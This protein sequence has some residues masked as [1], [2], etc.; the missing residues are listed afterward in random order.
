MRGMMFDSRNVEVDPSSGIKTS[1]SVAI[2]NVVARRQNNVADIDRQYAPF[3]TTISME[4][5]LNTI[6]FA[7][8]QIC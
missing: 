3:C 8:R 4:L 1:F 7:I 5:L 2:I 6:G